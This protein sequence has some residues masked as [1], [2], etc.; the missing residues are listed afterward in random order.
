[1]NQPVVMLAIGLLAGAAIG[2][3]EPLMPRVTVQVSPQPPQAVE[4]DQAA[5]D[6]SQPVDKARFAKH[7][8]DPG[9]IEEFK[10]ED[11]RDG[12]TKDDDYFKRLVARIK[13]TRR[14]NQL[15]LTLDDAIAR[16]LEHGFALKVA[17]YSP[18][19]EA[20][21]VVEAQAVF[22]ATLFSNL[23]KVIQDRP[24]GSQLS[25]SDFDRVSW[26]T[27]VRK[28]LPT[29]MQVSTSY[30]LDRQF[31]SL[32]FQQLNPQYFSQMNV[33][34]T[35]PLLRGFGLDYNRSAIL[36]ASNN[37]RVSD[38]EFRK[39]VRMSLRDLE[40][41]FWNL[42]QARRDVV[43]S[44]RLLEKFES[45]YIYL[46]ARKDFDV[47]DIQIQ[48]TLANLETSRA[49]FIRVLSTVRNAEDRIVFLL[50][51]P[52]LNLADDVEIIPEGLPILPRIVVDRVGEMQSA[53]ENRQEISEAELVVANAR[54][55]IGQ[56]RNE[57]LPRLDL[58]FNYAV[59]GL[60]K[61][62]DRSFD[63]WSRNN[64]NEY[65]IGVVF[66]MP[67]GNRAAKAR[68]YRARLSLSQAEE[69]L[70]QQTEL[71]LTEVN[72]SVRELDTSYSLIKP[73][74]ESV[75]ASQRQVEVIEAR[76][77]R[78]DFPQLN[79]ELSAR[80]GLASSRR[81]L[82]QALVDYQMSIINLEASK[83][84]LARYNNVV[85]EDEQPAGAH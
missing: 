83:G 43:I 15:H 42:V 38:A 84:T 7:L 50:N 62:A 69:R 78:K 6:A 72:V 11:L 60:G 54:I 85:F 27:G 23:N 14:P 63:E 80:N 82:L 66:E 24:S 18:A 2:S 58:S 45:I 67:I 73:R 13:A 81:Q 47:T 8:L 51:D 17:R 25:A 1:M 48:E 37:R 31:T 4:R 41:A 9:Q 12:D 28:I 55:G 10:E 16:M 65:T 75:E 19:I 74:L 53:L 36:L 34:L 26:E 68:L 46:V 5:T 64:F 32:S 49:D 20:T 44:A 21:R 35:Q 79:A 33:G 71:V 22:D 61:S 30:S 77:D 70:R 40:E 39:Q 29:G 57:T 52:T 56:A 3:D 59:D 76:A